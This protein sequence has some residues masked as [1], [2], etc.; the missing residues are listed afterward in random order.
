MAALALGYVAEP[1]YD[2]P[3][4][5]SI[6]DPNGVG[7]AIG[8]LRVPEGKTAKNP[9]HIDGWPDPAPTGGTRGGVVGALRRRTRATDPSRHALDTAG[10]RPAAS[11]RPSPADGPT[12]RSGE[13]RWLP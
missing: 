9:M 7:P 6:V 13:H 1:G 5:A 11:E 3:D 12:Y 4:G 10:G 8:F 2:H